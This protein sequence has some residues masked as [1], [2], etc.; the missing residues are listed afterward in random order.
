MC[1]PCPDGWTCCGKVWGTCICTHPTFDDCCTRADDPVC[2]TENGAC[3]ALKEPLKGILKGAAVIV[4]KS[5]VTLEAAKGALSV[6]QGFVSAAKGTLD[7][8]IAGLT[9]VRKTYRAGVEALNAFANFALTEIINIREMYFKV[10]LSVADGGEFQCQV[11]GVLMGNKI[12]VTLDFN[13]R[14]PLELAKSLGERAI[15]GISGFFG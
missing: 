13:I 10:A 15:S 4:D 8:A 6:A 1:I 9:A 3:A 14:N 2:L 11:K 12:D 7:I 5:R